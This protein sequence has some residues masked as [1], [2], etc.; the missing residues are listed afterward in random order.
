MDVID[1]QVMSQKQP[2]PQVRIPA[3]KSSVAIVLRGAG[4]ENV[5]PEKQ[6]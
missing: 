4:S 5:S 2:T 6:L 3:P 1:L